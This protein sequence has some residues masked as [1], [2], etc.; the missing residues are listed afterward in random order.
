MLPGNE[1]SGSNYGGKVFMPPSALAKLS[2][3]HI[4]YPMLFEITNEASKK[5]TH[6][7][8]L[9]FIAEEGRVY[10]PNWMMQTLLL[11]EGQFVQMRSTSLPLGK[12]VKIQPQSVD[13]LE[14]TDPKAVLEQALRSFSTLTV[15][16]IIAINYN[17][18]LYD[19]L[20][21]ETKPEGSGISIIET[22]LEV[23]FAPPVGYQEPE[24]PRRGPVNKSATSIE[25][26]TI[27]HAESF[28]AFSG[29]G[30][31][32]NGKDLSLFFGYPVIPVKSKDG[33]EANAD[34][35]KDFVAQIP[36]SHTTTCHMLE[37]GDGGT[38]DLSLHIASVFIILAVSFLG[39]TLPLAWNFWFKTG[40]HGALPVLLVKLFGAGVVLAA[41]LVHKFMPSHR[42][43]ATPCL[44]SVLSDHFDEVSGAIVL[45]GMLTTM[46]LHLLAANTMRRTKP[47][48]ALAA[49]ETPRTSIELGVV[50]RW[51]MDLG[52]A[53][54]SGAF[55]LKI[56]NAASEAVS[57]GPDNL[58]SDISVLA[59]PP[60]MLCIAAHSL[61]FG[62]SLGASR[63]KFRVLLVAL[64]FHQFIEGML[65]F[66]VLANIL[67]PHFQSSSFL[68]LAPWKQAFQIAAVALGVYSMATIGLW[69]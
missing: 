21:M 40:V 8:V 26:H 14:I 64:S 12:F 49:L 22:D 65:L 3:L 53:M 43:L 56:T 59:P 68:D 15:G 35:K 13:F 41:S 9:E 44:P 62:L 45:S 48:V 32:L 61:I 39:T 4:D 38:F 69:L 58:V 25:E 47:P 16:D 2:S 18:H 7:G 66:D 17:N 42:L 19:I 31:R 30:Q 20:V 23:D 28:S 10:I 52:E 37:A 63:D 67:A 60:A 6:A 54:L 46:L 29:S 57:E 33:V 34:A 24:R 50:R 36:A 11:Q 27:K 55:Q 51:S 5:A 1:K